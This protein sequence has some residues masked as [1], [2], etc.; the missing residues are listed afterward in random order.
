MSLAITNGSQV[1]PHHLEGPDA[2]S[3]DKVADKQVSPVSTSEKVAGVFGYCAGKVVTLA[4]MEASK[5]VG[6]AV[7]YNFAP[8]ACKAIANWTVSAWIPGA[9]TFAACRMLYSF[10]PT[11]ISATTWTCTG[12]A[13]LIS[14][15]VFEEPVANTCK[16]VFGYLNPYSYGRNNPTDKD[17]SSPEADS[18]VELRSVVPYDERASVRP[19]REESTN[20]LAIGDTDSPVP[21]A[22]SHLTAVAL[23]PEKTIVE[24]VQQYFSDKPQ[25]LRSFEALKSSV[26]EDSREEIQRY[27]NVQVSTLNPYQR[28]CLEALLLSFSSGTDLSIQQR[29]LALFLDTFNQRSSGPCS[30]SSSDF[31][32]LDYPLTDWVFVE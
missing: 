30:L 15:Q 4:T 27:Q 21:L 13:A 3:E 29:A 19:V 10:G 18:S 14:N 20:L 22:D 32:S 31:F 26:S 1:A 28:E 11:I 9:Q 6:A 12:V 5:A 7:G 25:A 16:K 17:Q 23:K 2:Q 24:N 8:W